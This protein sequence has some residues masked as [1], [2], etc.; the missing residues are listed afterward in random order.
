VC[1]STTAGREARLRPRGAGPGVD[2]KVV[3]VAEAQGDP[4]R[5]ARDTG[6]RRLDT[7]IHM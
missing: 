4:E 7:R 6:S 2:L 3:Q 1:G 5:T